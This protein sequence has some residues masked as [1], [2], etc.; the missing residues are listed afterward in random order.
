MNILEDVNIIIIY[1]NNIIYWMY[2]FIFI[3]LIIYIRIEFRI[4]NN[5]IFRN[6]NIYDFIKFK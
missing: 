6:S 2:L 4:F 1:Y 5:K 3:L